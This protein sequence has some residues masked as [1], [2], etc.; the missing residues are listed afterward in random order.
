MGFLCPF[1]GRREMYDGENV[2]KTRLCERDSGD[3]AWLFFGRG[4]AGKNFRL[5]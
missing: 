3:Y 1:K 4:Y 2:K 5:P